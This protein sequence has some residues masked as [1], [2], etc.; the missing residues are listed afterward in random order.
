MNIK[1]ILL[2]IS[3]GIVGSIGSTETKEV[4]HSDIGIS[5]EIPV[6]WDS[7]YYNMLTKQGYYGTMGKA[8]EEPDSNDIHV[9][10]LSYQEIEIDSTLL[11]AA[12]AFD[13]HSLNIRMFGYHGWYK[14]WLWS[15]GKASLMSQSSAFSEKKVEEFV[16]SNEEVL[17]DDDPRKIIKD[18][19]AI[20]YEFK[21]APPHVGS[22]GQI[23]WFVRNERCYRIAIE[24]VSTYYE[25]NR[26]MYN[27]VLAKMKIES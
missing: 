21:K 2:L 18:A 24:G 22:K 13:F 14:R 5:L 27:D 6:S 3:V 26:A 1:V 23:Y 10:F 15:Q 8:Y 9:A 19:H 20:E 7:T 11:P 12:E 4:D 17:A 16:S 25:E